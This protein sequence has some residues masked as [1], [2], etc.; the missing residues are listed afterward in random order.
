MDVFRRACTLAV[1]A[2][3]ATGSV[4]AAPVIQADLDA[5]LANAK[6]TW[7]NDL[8]VSIRFEK[9]KSCET[10]RVAE[11]LRPGLSAIASTRRVDN[12]TGTAAAVWFIG[13]NSACDWTPWYL[14]KVVLHE[15]GHALGLEHSTD[16]HSIMFWL[17]F[18]RSA[19]RN[20][21][22]QKITASD[23]NRLNELKAA[24]Q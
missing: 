14:R 13:I 8:V 7:M 18:S 16:P 1:A 19:A 5:A 9:M 24:A 23:L 11:P 21:G 3:L 6:K 20:Y 2:M 4:G 15:Y 12:A 17:V 10:V 22:P